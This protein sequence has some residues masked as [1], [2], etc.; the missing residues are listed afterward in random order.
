MVRLE[1]MFLLVQDRCEV[2]D[3]CTIGSEIHLGSPDGTT[4]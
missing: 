1:K 3:K 4:K 2:C